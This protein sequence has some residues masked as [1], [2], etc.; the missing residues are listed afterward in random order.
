VTT[1]P[2]A[3]G[4]DRTPEGVWS[5]LVAARRRDIAARGLQPCAETHEPITVDACERQ[6][7]R[8]RG[9][10]K[11]RCRHRSAASCGAVATGRSVAPEGAA[12][13]SVGC[14]HPDRSGRGRWPWPCGLGSPVLAFVLGRGPKPLSSDA[15]RVRVRWRKPKPLPAGASRVRVRWRGPKPLPADAGRSRCPDLGPFPRGRSDGP[16]VATPLPLRA[17]GGRRL[18]SA[19][20]QAGS[21]PLSG[22]PLRL[23]SKLVRFHFPRGRV[24]ISVD[25]PSGDSEETLSGRALLKPRPLAACLLPGSGERA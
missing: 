8:R 23:S 6:A 22:G 20:Q 14:C 21:L 2:R 17:L 10:N 25:P 3:H 12:F 4:R 1:H 5:R 18:A 24:A 13:R 11:V 16:E 9:P 15:G 7:V 19:L